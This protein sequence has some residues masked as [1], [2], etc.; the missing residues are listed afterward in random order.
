MG[1]GALTNVNF[2]KLTTLLKVDVSAS[3]T[4]CLDLHASRCGA[5]CAARS[6]TRAVH[7]GDSMVVVPALKEHIP[8]AIRS[9]T[10][11]V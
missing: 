11:R 8:R 9:S 5:S 3:G 10:T 7:K 1:N 4:P 2:P 6:S